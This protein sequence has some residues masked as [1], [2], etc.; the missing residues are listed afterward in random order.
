MGHVIAGV[1][2]IYDR[3]EYED[4]KADAL[5]KLAGL[6]DVKIHECG[7][8]DALPMKLKGKCFEQNADTARGWR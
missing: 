4:E 8:A 3:H 6:I 5:K 2:G 7:G 1:E